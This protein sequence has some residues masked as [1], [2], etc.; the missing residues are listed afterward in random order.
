MIPHQ[1]T[2]TVERMTDRALRMV[3]LGL[4]VIAVTD[5]WCRGPARYLHPFH[6]DSADSSVRKVIA[7]FGV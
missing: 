6:Q 5:H 4:D 7:R 3:Q 2:G 1:D